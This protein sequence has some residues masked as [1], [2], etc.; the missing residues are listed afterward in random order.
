MAI[1]ALC[2]TLTVT[3]CLHSGCTGNIVLRHLVAK[4]VVDTPPQAAPGSPAE[5]SSRPDER[6]DG[7]TARDEGVSLL[8][9]K[10]ARWQRR[11]VS[12]CHRLAL[13][14]VRHLN[15]EVGRR[16]GLQD[17]FEAV[18]ERHRRRVY[19]FWVCRSFTNLAQPSKTGDGGLRYV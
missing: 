11:N 4:L 2:L 15:V 7:G 17:G 8:L 13:T 5:N 14:S 12:R 1:S 9:L 16:R 10:T 19:S 6:E 18:Y 3:F